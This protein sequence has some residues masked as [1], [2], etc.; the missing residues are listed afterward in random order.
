[1]L[2]LYNMK[3]L[4]ELF[5]STLSEKSTIVLQLGHLEHRIFATQL[6]LSIYSK[7]RQIV[8]EGGFII[9]K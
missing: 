9:P 2:L 6:F 7:I 3:H 1:V 5:L 4:H 8:A